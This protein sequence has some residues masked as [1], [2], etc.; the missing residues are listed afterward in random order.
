MPPVDDIKA[1]IEQVLKPFDE[2]GENEDGNRSN[3]AFW[4]FYVIGGRFAGVKLE[5]MFDADRLRAFNT[6]LANQKV[7]VR[8]VQFGKQELAPSSQIP[9]VDAL[10][11][12]SFPESPIK[13]CPMFRHYND[14]HEDSNGFPDIMRLGDVP[15]SLK[16]FRVIVAGPNHRGELEATYMIQGDMWNGVS[17]VDTRWDGLVR[18]TVDALREKLGDY[19]P[20]Y[21]ARNTPNDD[22][23]A[24]TVDYHS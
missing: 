21:A 16:A 20:E 8:G 4:D 9:M 11:C 5:A 7:T 15:A 23:L 2:N 14:Q 12:E 13:V 1:A 3:H 22:W 18:S 19:K 24:V 6:E 17:W 10:W